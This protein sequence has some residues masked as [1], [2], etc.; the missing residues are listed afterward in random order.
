[1]IVNP[2]IFVYQTLKEM[3]IQSA[4]LQFLR[5]LAFN[6]HREW[7]QAN[8]GRYEAAL[9]NMKAFLKAAENALNETDHLEEA[10]LFR[11]YRDVRFSQ[12]KSPYKNHFGMGF[13]RATKKLRGGYYLHIEPG[14]SFAGGGF[15]QP[16]AQDLKRIR[17]EFAVDD[18]PIRQIMADPTFREF[19]GSLE[20]EELKTAPR[21]F[22]KDHPALDLIRKKSFVVRRPFSDAEVLAPGFL[23]EV[24]RTFEA[25]R[26]YFDYM[27]MVLTTD[28]NGESLVD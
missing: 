5:D 15:W 22:D 24:K 7:F 18:Q 27:S 2:V 8:K 11:I 20:G 26:P 12:D 13:S 4:T 23:Q 6:N 14:A 10:S 21:G 28:M 25:M 9:A 17:D 1:M 16:N 19:F 3:T